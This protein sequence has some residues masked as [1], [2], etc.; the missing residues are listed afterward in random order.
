[1]EYL[2]I[3]AG[4]F[5]LF[6]VHKLILAPMRHLVVNVVVGLIVLYGVNHFGYLF[7]FQH[8]P[9]TVGTGL[10]IGLF[11]LLLV[12]AISV[13]YA[14]LMREQVGGAAVSLLGTLLA[15]LTTWLSFGLLAVSSTPAVS[16]F[17]LSVSLGLA[18]SFI[19]AP[20]AARQ[21]PTA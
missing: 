6:L 1:M 21:E 18:F 15:A 4:V 8:V 3:A 11:G 9:I 5:G 20:W 13:D 7:G 19:L 2:W 14:I 10:I 12:T 17:G 16:N